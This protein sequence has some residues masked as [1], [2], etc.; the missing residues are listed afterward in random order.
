MP[1][2][3]TDVI[4]YTT[5]IQ[6]VADGDA[7][8][9]ANFALAPQGLAN[10]TAFL[11]NILNTAGVTLLRS[12][13]SATMQALTGVANGSVFFVLG[14]GLYVYLTAGAATV[15]SKFVY[16]A[17]GMGIGQWQ[18]ELLSL[19]DSNLGLAAVGPV[20]G[21]SGVAANKLPVSQQT[22]C[23][24]SINSVGVSSSFSTASGS[25]VD[26]TSFTL[27]VANCVTGDLLVCSMDVNITSST[28]NTA[29]AAINANGS[30]LAE[31]FT[32]GLN[33]IIVNQ[34]CRGVF[35]APSSGS[36]VIKG[37]LKG[38]A[39]SLNASVVSRLLVEQ[40]RP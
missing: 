16:T 25:Y 21:S 12:G 1:N 18:H 40:Y 6:T 36:F 35:T 15:D 9:G 31:V 28:T 17:T 10:R 34:S 30:V 39:A 24:I 38:A 5:P 26:I 8:S 37:Q 23:L 27:S 29:A 20:S 13:S 14:Q 3:I 22:N 7:G 33:G 4:T 32:S 2:N 11:N 19:L